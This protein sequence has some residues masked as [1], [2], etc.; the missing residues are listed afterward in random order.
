MPSWSAAR[1]QKLVQFDD[2]AMGAMMRACKAVFENHIAE[3]EGSFLSNGNKGIVTAAID[4]A[5]ASC[6]LLK[7]LPD[8][9]VDEVKKELRLFAANWRKQKRSTTQG[10]KFTPPGWLPS[11]FF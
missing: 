4:A 7:G 3:L 11:C 1:F 10:T 2:A 9:K 8:S 5:F 6:D